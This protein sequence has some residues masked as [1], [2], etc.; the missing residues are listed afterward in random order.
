MGTQDIVTKEYMKDEH[1]FADAFNYYLFNGEPIVRAEQL[2]E[3]DPVELGIILDAVNSVTVQKIR[4]VLKHALLLT[5]E[6]CNYLLLGIENQSEVHLAMPVRNLIFDGLRYG[7]Q[8]TERAKERRRQKLAQD[9]VEFLSGLGREDRIKPEITLVIY[10]KAGPWDGPRSLYDMFD[11]LDE[12]IKDYVN[13]Y[14]LHIIVP[15][16]IEDF[17]KFGT[18]LGV[19]FEFIA[20][21]QNDERIEKLENN[22]RFAEVTNET[23]HLL[24]VCADAHIK[25][26]EKEGV[27]NMCKGIE[28]LKVRMRQEG[29]RE[30]QLEGRKAEF[31]NGIERIAKKVGGIQNACNLYDVTVEAYQKAKNSLSAQ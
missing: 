8:I 12:R 16:E 31:V 10:W 11:P 29:H 13:D 20:N 27:V 19:A 24:N 30:G 22:Q 18:E 23:A 1:R 25:L 28:D 14:K 7:E 5:D 2:R 3:T 21:S 4:D 9:S 26:D 6:N 17:E 15:D